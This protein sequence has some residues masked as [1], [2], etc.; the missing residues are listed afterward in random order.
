MDGT[1]PAY[2]GDLLLVTGGNQCLGG[3][4]V[5]L[6][7]SHDE[8]RYRRF[9]GE[10][11][12]RPAWVWFTGDAPR[13]VREK[14]DNLYERLVDTDTPTTAA[15]H[16][17]GGYSLLRVLEQ[18]YVEGD[19]LEPWTAVDNIIALQPPSGI[20]HPD[21][22]TYSIGA[23]SEPPRTDVYVVYAES[24][25]PWQRLDGEYT[26]VTVATSTTGYDF[27]EPTPAQMEERVDVHRF[28]DAREDIA[29]TVMGILS[30]ETGRLSQLPHVSIDRQ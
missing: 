12:E 2:D 1:T 29:E 15:G 3:L 5:F 21:G 19:D 30:G 9:F 27:D 4:E 6:K 18:S 7:R 8:P 14:T 17:A 24:T 23:V 28:A 26:Q 16:C 10:G 13:Q 25:P 22:T 11:T 20:Q